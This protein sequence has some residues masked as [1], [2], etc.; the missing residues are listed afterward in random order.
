M[1]RFLAALVRPVVKE[2]IRQVYV[3]RREEAKAEGLNGLERMMFMVFGD[4]SL[5][6]PDDPQEPSHGV[7]LPQATPKAA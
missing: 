2:A 3:A 6:P 1:V 7:E 4:D 5:S